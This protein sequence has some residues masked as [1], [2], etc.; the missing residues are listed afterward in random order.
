MTM[1]HLTGTQGR[2]ERTISQCA[3]THGFAI[4]TIEICD[5][6]IDFSLPSH[7]DGILS[8]AQKHNRPLVIGTTGYSDAQQAQINAASKH[9]AIFQSA[10]FSPG[11]HALSRILSLV[12]T[13]LPTWNSALI[14][15]HH[16]YKTDAPSGT[17]L[18]LMHSGQIDTVHSLRGGTVC[19]M[20]EIRLL[21][22]D[23]HIQI[24]HTAE[25]RAV[26]AHGAL[27][28]AA[29][30]I[31]QPPGLYGMEDLLS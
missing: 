3:P 24:I 10:N 31:T 12:C 25:S 1:L 30:I 17:A 14:E 13:L 11:I 19:G 29:W 4:G 5:V 9:I 23:E 27:D 22:Q 18:A 8:D 21:G 16:R 6:I 28:A 2:M 15:T 20:H 26:F 7:I